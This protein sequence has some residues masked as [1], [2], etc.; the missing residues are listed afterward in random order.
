MVHPGFS[1]DK[2]GDD[3]LY[4]KL[5]EISM[6][7]NFAYQS[8]NTQM[9][10]QL[11]LIYDT[12]QMELQERSIL[13]QDQKASNIV[14]ETDPDMKRINQELDDTNTKKNKNNP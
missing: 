3:E 10:E 4:K 8:G 9:L 5:G 2:F 1:T 13:K 12:L 7:I 11:N 14:I 6:R